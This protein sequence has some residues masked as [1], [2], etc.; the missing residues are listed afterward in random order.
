MLWFRDQGWHWA[1]GL[2]AALAFSYGASMAWRIQHIGQ[3]LSLAYLP[4]AL[5]CL[6]R[7]LARGSILYGV[8]AGIVAAVIVLGRDQVALLGDLSAGGLRPLAHRCRRPQPRARC[9]RACCRWRPARVCA[10][11]DRRRAR[12]ADGPAGRRSPTAPSIDYIGAGARLAA[13]GPAA[14]AGDAGR[15]RRRGPHGGLLG[16]AELRLARYRP[17]HR[18]EHGPALHRRHSA[19]AAAD[20]PPCAASCGR[21]RSASSPVAAAV[22]LL[23][24]LGWYTPVFRVPLRAAAGR[25]PLPPA[26][27]RDVPG[28]RAGRDPGG[29]WRASAV[30]RTAGGLRAPA[31]AIVAGRDRWRVATCCAIALAAVARPRA[32]AAAAARRGRGLVRGGG[33]GARLGDADASPSSRCWRR[34]CSPASRP[35]ISPTTTA[36]AP[37]RP[38]RPRSTTCWSPTPATP[39]SPS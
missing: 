16:P 28:R 26:G 2:I 25:Q 38:S 8:A 39:P 3:V 32:A 6:D 18:P 14:D 21:R 9:A 17:V 15:V 24:A 5:V 22:V 37:P 33:A 19:A 31:C 27:G 36:P 4:I 12:A 23:Y 29:L 20:W 13:S 10:L 35:S 34:P 11:A 30:P 1:G 7:A